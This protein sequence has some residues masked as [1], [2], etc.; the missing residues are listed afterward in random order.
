MSARLPSWSFSKLMVFEECKYRAKLQWLDKIP[1][2]QP[3]TAADR[4]S[5]I[6]LECEDYVIGKDGFT[7]NLRFFKDDLESLK[8]HF[9]AGRVICE[10]EWAFDNQWRPT[11]WK[12]GWLRLKADAV[13]FLTKT[14]CVVIDYKTG[15]RFGNEI[16]HARQLQLYAVCA[17]LLYPELQ[18]VTCELWYLDQNELSKFTM[19]RSQLKKYLQIYDRLGREFTSEE[20]FPPSPN[21]F[22]CK[23]CPYGPDKQGDCK[24]GVSAD[25]VKAKPFVIEIKPVTPLAPMKDD[26]D[27]F[28]GR[29]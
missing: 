22:S 28:K 8:V 15:K 24:Y 11:E 25:N 5:A 6:H 1:D 29:F 10:Q 4:G 7:H 14:H 3:K 9:A 17:L 23:W 2:L 26:M 19:R 16:K 20:D 13:C 21:I 12:R 27:D 18:S